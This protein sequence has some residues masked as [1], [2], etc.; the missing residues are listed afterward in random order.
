MKLFAILALSLALPVHATGKH[1]P[2]IPNMPAEIVREVY[3]DSNREIAKGMLIG[4]GVALL[5]R[6]LLDKRRER[7]SEPVR[8]VPAECPAVVCP[9]V[10]TCDAQVTR[11]LEA[12]G[13]SK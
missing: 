11:T 10:P 5:V 8:I 6:H 12:C 13:V 2:K 4:A 9:T 3:R 1:D 7:M